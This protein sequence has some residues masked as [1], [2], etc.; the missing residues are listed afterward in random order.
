MSAAPRWPA[1]RSWRP[2]LGWFFLLSLVYT[3]QQKVPERAVPSFAQSKVV[4]NG[5]AFHSLMSSREAPVVVPKLVQLAKAG[6]LV[7]KEVLASATRTS[8]LPRRPGHEVRISLRQLDGLPH[9]LL[10]L[11]EEYS[12]NTFLG[13][14]L[15]VADH[16]ILKTPAEMDRQTFLGKLQSRGW[17]LKSELASSQCVLVGLPRIAPDVLP[18]A[19]AAAR[20]E[21]GAAAVQ[22]DFL[23]SSS[24]SVTDPQFFRSWGLANEGQTGG[25][26]GADVRARNAWDRQLG[27]P[28]VTV[29]LIDSGVDVTHPELAGTLYHNPGESGG[30]KETNGIDDDGNGRIDDWRGWNFVGNNNAPLDDHLH[31]THICGI[32]AATAN[33][34]QGSCGV[35]RQVKVLPIKILQPVTIFGM[36]TSDSAVAYTSDA[37]EAIAYAQAQQAAIIS[38]SWGGMLP[39]GDVTFLPLLLAALESYGGAG[40]MVVASAGNEGVSNDAPYYRTFPASFSLPC[41]LS[42]TSSDHRDAKPSSANFGATRVHLAAPGSSIYS[43]LPTTPT[44]AMQVMGLSTGYGTLSGTSMAVPY[45]VGGLV[46]LKAEYPTASATSLI[47]RIVDYVDFVPAFQYSVASKGRLNI[48]AALRAP[49][50]DARIVMKSWRATELQPVPQ[51]NAVINRGESWDFRVT[52]E[53]QGSAGSVGV[54][55][56]SMNCQSPHISLVQGSSSFGTLAPGEAKFGSADFR[57]AVSAQCPTPHPFELQLTFT[58]AAGSSWSTQLVQVVYHSSTVQGQLI[59][60]ATGLPI[61]GGQVSGVGA[62]ATAVVSTGSD[63]RFTLSLV[64]GPY[65]LLV[66]APGHRELWQSLV[67]P[68]FFQP[69][70]PPQRLLLHTVAPAVF[71]HR[72]ETSLAPNAAPGALD[73]QIRAAGTATLAWSAWSNAV[74]YAASRSGEPGGPVYQWRPLSAAAQELPPDRWLLALPLG[75][76]FPFYGRLHNRIHLSPHGYAVMGNELDP[77]LPATLPSPFPTGNLPGKNGDVIAWH[78]AA[79]S[80]GAT[81]KIRWERLDPQTFVIEYQQMPLAGT[82]GVLSCQCVLKSDGSIEYHYQNPGSAALAVVGIQD[83]SRTRGL[84]LDFAAQRQPQQAWR[85]TPESVGWGSC[86]AQGTLGGEAATN[87]TLQLQPNGLPAGIHQASVI[88]DSDSPTV[89]RLIVPVS[90]QIGVP[91]RVPWVRATDAD[92]LT[93]SIAISWGTSALATSYDVYRQT[94]AGGAWQLLGN[95]TSA[96][97]FDTTAQSGL[98]YAYHVI[99]RQGALTAEP[100]VVEVG[101]YGNPLVLEKPPLIDAR[102]LAVVAGKVAGVLVHWQESLA[103]QA[104]PACLEVRRPYEQ[105]FTK[106]AQWTNAPPNHTTDPA[107]YLPSAQVSYRL[108]V[109]AQVITHSLTL[110]AELN[111]APTPAALPA[112]T[113]LANSFSSG[114]LANANIAGLLADPDR[115]GMSNLMEYALGSQPTFPDVSKLPQPSGASGFT[116][117]TVPKNPQSAGLRYAV[118]F[119][120]GDQVW[121]SGKVEQDTPGQLRVRSQ[122]PQSAIPRQFTRLRVELE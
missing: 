23:F 4:G 33:N 84:N 87:A 101:I 116:Q 20:Q 58:D 94:N 74:N 66:K 81:G 67:A 71:P 11:E 96:Q 26:P 6:R 69:D 59:S 64:D 82:G 111:T 50:G 60:A 91:S 88:I 119:S 12:G 55:T 31:G 28:A 27:S 92:E 32:L 90:L 5:E 3:W 97:F 72:L 120:S 63:G 89:P 75:F 117:L 43:T 47:R 103:N 100:S 57:I 65:G 25:L 45:V 40:G 17:S 21:F 107:T 110:S 80:P 99:A 113:W 18:E 77:T 68:S 78:W 73:F 15:V 76:S 29:A 16:F 54:V 38:I 24:A 34:G 98:C 85:L 115:D 44:P 39:V 105:N 86:A 35:C 104:S 7:G 52:A 10:R 37:L 30:G 42:V 22:A 122:Q 61:I 106:L 121:Q 36:P 46:L 109:G 9:S 83:A 95:T 112:T 13:S 48:N 79:F 70:L 56:A 118:E 93:G 102:P 2:I 1:R 51:R 49:A 8:L 62:R 114:D 14:A 19:L 41:L 108:T 53:N